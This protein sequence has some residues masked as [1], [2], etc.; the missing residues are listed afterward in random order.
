METIAY[1]GIDVS[2]GSADFLLVNTRKETLEEGFVLDDCSQGRKVLTRLIDSWFT[3]GI[4][5][6]YCGVEST[7]GYENNWF[8][9]LCSLAAA[10][11]K[12]NKTLR[13]A[14]VNPRPVKA[15]GQA[16]MLRTQTD[17][18]SAFA[19]ASYLIGFPEKVRYSPMTR[20]VGG[21]LVAGGP[22]TGRADPHA[23]QAKERSCPASLKNC[24][25]AALA[26]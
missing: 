20:P 26:R 4:T 18:T 10:Y 21:S 24:S 25:I 7:G 12:K 2:K 15:C 5:H 16:A 6:L 22:R 3:G 13:V 9:L 1:L 11:D 23:H 19:I 14:R 8:N 17:Q